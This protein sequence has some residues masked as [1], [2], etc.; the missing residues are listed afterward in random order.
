MD[1]DQT[2][3]VWTNGRC[4][5]WPDA[6]VHLSAHALHY[7]TGV[8]E[9]LRCYETANGPAVF[10]ME[11][12]LD[13]FYASAAHYQMNIPYAHEEMATAIC[14]IIARNQFSNCYI[15]PICFFGSSSLGLHPRK[16]PV[17]VAILAWPWGAYLGEETLERGVRITISPWQKFHP[18][19]MPTTAK[20]CGQYLN[21][22][23][24][25]RDAAERGF[26]EALLLDAHGNIAE[27]SGENIFLIRRDTLLTND[28]R[29]SIL[30]GITRDCVIEI[31]TAA[32]LR[33][34][35][36]SLTVDDL[37]QCDEAF[38]TGTA[39]EVVPICELD[40]NQIGGG[41]RGP[42]TTKLQQTF[43]NATAGRDARYVKWLHPVAQFR[44]AMA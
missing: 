13:R 39:A 20:A 30:L 3:W 40:G 21:S 12:H 14:E 10:R 4:V 23:L 2:Q 5:R 29:D 27:G 35:T 6:T 33:V 17:E 34:E 43:M 26:H 32:G 38:F 15:R 1:F 31:A 7:G 36:R 42:H 41:K 8:F 9:G 37:L 16:C 18:K 11:A 44:E 28:E 22:V 25:I 19:M 24:A